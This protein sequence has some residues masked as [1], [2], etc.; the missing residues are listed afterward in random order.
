MKMYL[1]LADN[2][3]F[4]DVVDPVLAGDARSLNFYQP[5]FMRTKILS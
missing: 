4:M 2:R 1:S 5:S 3:E